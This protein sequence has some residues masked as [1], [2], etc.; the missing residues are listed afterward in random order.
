VSIPRQLDPV[1]LRQ[2]LVKH[3]SDSELRGLCFD[4]SVDYEILPGSDKARKVIELITFLEHRGRVPELV[5]MV[6]AQRPHLRWDDILLSTSPSPPS[7]DRQVDET[8]TQERQVPGQPEQRIAEIDRFELEIRPDDSVKAT[9]ETHDR[10][11]RSAN[12]GVNDDRDVRSDIETDIARLRRPKQ[13]SPNVDVQ[14]LGRNLY[15]AIF[16]DDVKTL[17]ERAL[18]DVI[19]ERRRDRTSRRWL[20]VVIDV[21]ADSKVFNWPLELLYCDRFEYWLATET[22]QIAL[23]RRT[24]AHRIIE[25]LPPQDPPLRVLMVISEPQG[26]DSQITTT[27]LQEI[28]ELAEPED[29]DGEASEKI[30][31]KVL[32]IVQGGE[33]IPGIDY[34][35]QPATYENLRVWTAERWQPHLLH[36]IAHGRYELESGDLALVDDAGQADWCSPEDV[37]RLFRDWLPHLVLLQACEGALSGTE[38]GFVNLADRLAMHGIPA[39]VATQFSISNSHAALFAVGLYEALRE[40]QDV[41][42]AVQNGRSKIWNKAGRG[43][44]S[45]HHFGTPVLFTYSPGAIIHTQTRS[46][47]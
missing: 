2:V 23:S 8:A 19:L 34:L 36:F 9:L 38:P 28:G 16:Q 20:R 7:R 31:I 39:V 21:D 45:E 3:F 24:G 35:N 37:S 14:R 12:G 42:R 33:H 1:Q 5:A 47:G 18:E 44:G 17:F 22:P 30:E 25:Q 41:D 13:E 10:R 29:G 11:M 40:G 6:Q 43:R 32:G 15:R 4:L 27:I 46:M 26:L